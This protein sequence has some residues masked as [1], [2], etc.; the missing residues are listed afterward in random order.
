MYTVYMHK[1]PNGKVYVG[2]TKNSV[3]TRWANGKGY[4]HNKRMTNAIKKYSWENIIHIIIAENLT[5]EEACKL[6]VEKIKEFDST[7]EENGYNYSTGGQS[8]AA[9]VRQSQE[10]VRKRI[11]N[12]NGGVNPFLGKKH[13]EE[14]KKKM[15]AACK[16]RKR[17]EEDKRKISQKMKGVK[18]TEETKLRMKKAQEKNRKKVICL[19]TGVIYD[20]ISDAAKAI[21]ASSSNVTCACNGTYKTTHKMEF[22]FFEE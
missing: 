5:K 15:S 13:T 1:F 9:G 8:G 16:G 19:T 6:E 21:G 20:S 12:T 3:Y 22:R 18:K 11:Q 17:S 7:N 10:T 4:N 2:I 14:A